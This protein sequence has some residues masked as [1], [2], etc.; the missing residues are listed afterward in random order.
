MSVWSA[1]WLNSISVEMMVHPWVVSNATSP[2]MTGT[3]RWR[4]AWAM[5]AVCH[6]VMVCALH[7]SDAEGCS[8]MAGMPISRSVSTTIRFRRSAAPDVRARPIQSSL[9]C[10]PWWMWYCAAYTWP[11]EPLPW[12][13]T[14]CWGCAVST[15][16][17]SWLS[18]RMMCISTS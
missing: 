7:C 10:S 4:S 14:R 1:R 2:W 9:G 5:V 3:R 13:R 16:C 12:P 18:V 17:S 6:V 15:L 8:E 11:N